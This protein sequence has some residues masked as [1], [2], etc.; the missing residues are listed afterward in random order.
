[1]HILR[2]QVKRE[3]EYWQRSM[4]L[5][6]PNMA[7]NL[8]FKMQCLNRGNV[9]F[10]RVHRSAKVIFFCTSCLKKTVLEGENMHKTQFILKISVDFQQ[11][12]QHTCNTVGSPT[13]LHIKPLP[14]TKAPNHKGCNNT[15]NSNS[16]KYF[17]F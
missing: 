12:I 2:N 16:C 7:R 3:R 15:N 5:G 17:K 14:S 9:F 11:V 8:I 1:M 10:S 4:C 13:F 6:N